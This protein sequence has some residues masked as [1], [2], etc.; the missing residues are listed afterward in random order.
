MDYTGGW[1]GKGDSLG[2]GDLLR[3]VRKYLKLTGPE[4]GD[5]VGLSKQ[6]V[7]MIETGNNKP[8]FDLMRSIYEKWSIDPRYW[9]GMYEDVREADLSK[10]RSKPDYEQLVGEIRDLRRHVAPI[11]SIDPLAERVMINAKLRD[12]V[13][14]LQ[15]LDA[16]MLD[17]IGALVFGYMA[18]KDRDVEKGEAPA[19]KEA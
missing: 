6:A 4:F 3:E 19:R 2:T 11:K 15:Y 16:G 1:E 8:T 18:A 7:S 12:L 9:F 5:A 14:R 13:S 17:Q 10:E